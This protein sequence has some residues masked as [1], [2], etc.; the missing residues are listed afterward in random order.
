MGER[1]IAEL[2]SGDGGLVLLVGHLAAHAV[3]AVGARLLGI[4]GIVIHSFGA[5]GSVTSMFGG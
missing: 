2:G 1:A 5:S 4:W 3:H